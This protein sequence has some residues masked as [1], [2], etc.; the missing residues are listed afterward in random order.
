M[1][2]IISVF[3]VILVSI[4]IVSCFEIVPNDNDD[5]NV[6]ENAIYQVPGCAAGGLEKRAGT[7]MDSCFTYQFNADLFIEFCVS[8]NCCPDTNRFQS[9]WRISSDTIFVDVKDIEANLCR[10]ICPYK[11]HVELIDLP[12]DQYTFLVDYNGK[13]VYSESVVR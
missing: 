7:L 1:I 12:L 2:R 5:N 13:T 11:I 10:C 3:V 4:A 8:A 6:K 9:S